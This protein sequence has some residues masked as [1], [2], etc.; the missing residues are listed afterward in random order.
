MITTGAPR[1]TNLKPAQDPTL[2]SP[3]RELTHV[4]SQSH[5]R[6]PL[7]FDMPS[8]D[9]NAKD[10]FNFPGHAASSDRQSL[11]FTTEC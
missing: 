4:I 5:Y 3:S 2:S 8:C 9:H 7:Y 10:C 11:V 1:I 6:D